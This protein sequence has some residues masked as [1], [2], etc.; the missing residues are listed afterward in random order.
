MSDDNFYN[1][2]TKKVIRKAIDKNGNEVEIPKLKEDYSAEK[3]N[4]NLKFYT[5]YD[6]ITENKENYIVIMYDETFDSTNSNVVMI[7]ITLKNEES[8]IDI[9]DEDKIEEIL[10]K[11]TN[12][13]IEYVNTKQSK[14]Y[15]KVQIKGKTYYHKLNEKNMDWKLS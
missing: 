5:I 2:K 13:E 11:Y 6:V 4:Q 9:N 7:T 15:E 3:P 1:C 10:E 12:Y 14:N 8:L